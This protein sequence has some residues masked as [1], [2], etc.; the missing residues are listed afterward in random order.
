MD[1]ILAVVLVFIIVMGYVA[2][3]K[4]ILPRLILKEL[5]Q[6]ENALTDR[7][8]EEIRHIY[9][10]MRGWRHDYRNHMQTLLGYVKNKEWDACK[11]YITQLNEDLSDIDHVIKTGNIMADAV[12]NS[13]VSLARAKEIPMDIT[14]QIPEEMPISDVEFSVLFGNLMDNAIEACEKLPNKEERFLRVYIG[15]FRKQF[16][17]SVTN[18]TGEKVRRNTYVSLKGEGHGFGLYRM[19]KIVKKRGGYL[20]RKNEPGVFATE[21]MLPFAG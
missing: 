1:K 17:I 21:I 20:N 14:V 8:F 13:K 3:V 9:Q 19:D 6:Y 4:W 5:E 12:V 18:S 16:Y 15:M 7:Q 2:V 10:E 11:K